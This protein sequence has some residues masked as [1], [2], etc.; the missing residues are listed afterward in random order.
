MRPAKEPV[1]GIGVSVFL[2]AI[3]AFAVHASVSGVDIQVI[4]WILMGCGVL[5]LFLTT[6]AFGRRDRV[7][8]DPPVVERTARY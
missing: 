2:L 1:L 4:G 3:L 8:T 6:L 5:G 7:V